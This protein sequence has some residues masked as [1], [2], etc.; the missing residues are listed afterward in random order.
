VAERIFGPEGGHTQHLKALLEQQGQ[1]GA[2]TRR[3]AEEG[4]GPSDER[5]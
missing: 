1:S 3:G 2:S 5:R 4:I